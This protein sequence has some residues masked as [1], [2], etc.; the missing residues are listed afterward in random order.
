MMMKH[1]AFSDT[2]VNLGGEYKNLFVFD[3]DND[4]AYGTTYFRKQFSDR[5]VACGLA[6]SHML[7]MAAGMSLRG[8]IV[9]VCGMSL[10]SVGHLWE[11]IR[12]LVC[13]PHLNVKIIGMQSILH[14]SKDEMAFSMFEDIALMRNFSN[15][16][17]LCPADYFECV[18]MLEAMVFDFGPAYIRICP[19]EAPVLYDKSYTFSFGKGN[20]IRHGTDMVIFSMGSMVSVALE[21]AQ[22]FEKEDI[23]VKVV[24][25]SCLQPLDEK[26][27]LENVSG[28][29]NIFTLEEH[30]IVG[31]LGSSVLEILHDPLKNVG[32]FSVERIGIDTV[33]LDVD[34]VFQ[35]MKSHCLKS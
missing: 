33:F 25:L 18:R 31:G 4:C 19:N 27:I 28:M 35:H 11:Q 32:S 8:K 15:M 34:S 3:A 17:I 14:P 9:L 23:S 10:F 21:V 7:G 13:Y 12:N 20:V 22:K 5:Y 26:L 30:H 6:R 29:Q 2:L 1:N 16:K 24:N